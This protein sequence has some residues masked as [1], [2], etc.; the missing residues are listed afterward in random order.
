MQKH[1]LY[2]IL[3]FVMMA[4]GLNIVAIKILVQN[5][6][7]FTI[8]GLRILAAGLV[9]FVFLYVKKDLQKM[10]LH[11][12]GYVALSAVTGI[13]G[14]QALLSVGL[15]NTSA[16][17]G[18]SILALIPLVTNIL[19]VLFLKAKMTF[20]KICGVLFGMIGIYFILVLGGG[21]FTELSSGDLFVFL[22]V[23][24]Q[25]LSFIFIRKASYT[26]NPKTITCYALLM[27][28]GFLVMLSFALEG[29][30]I[31]QIGAAPTY[32][33]W[34]FIASAIISTGIGNLC[35]NFAISQL[36]AGETAIFLNLSPFF[37]LVGSVLFLNEA[38]KWIQLVGFILIVIGVLLGTELFER[39]PRVERQV[40]VSVSK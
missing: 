16:T 33:W 2:G 14:H 40:G 9:I 30:S 39:K 7:P 5:F 18:A 27:G 36:G 25:A 12:F 28:A 8:T 31:Q 21:S 29:Q 23:I 24:A 6:P 35:Y 10:N 32:V 13:L 4:W 11:E 3:L 1:Y 20:L 17:N 19:A 38:F 37:S 26:L 22:S 15:V 34:V